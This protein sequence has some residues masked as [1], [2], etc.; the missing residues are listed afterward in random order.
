MSVLSDLTQAGRINGTTMQA[1]QLVE[2]GRFE[3]VEAPLPEPEP[4]Q[5]R[6]RLEGC[7][8]C[9]SNV[10]PFEGRDWFTYPMEPGALGHEGW[11]HIDALGEGVKGLREGDRVAFLGQKSYAQYDVCNSSAV[12]PAPKEL[13]EFPGEPLG[14]CMNIFSRSRIKAGDKVAI[15]GVGFLGALLTQLAAKEGAEVI[16]VA[17][18][19]YALQAAEQFGA[20]HLV[21]MDDHNRIIQEVSDLTGGV[22]CDVVIEATGKPWPLDLAAELTKERGR[23]IVAGFHQDGPRQ[24]NMFLWNWRGLDVINAHERDEVAYIKGMEAAID[25]V[26][27]FRLTPEPL[28]THRFGLNHLTEALTLTKERPDGFMKALISMES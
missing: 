18:K 21:T 3:V 22:F 11:G 24:I 9:A 14:C 17:R 19:P 2:P 12:V 8:V 6:I 16:A 4:G 23:L 27:S 10:P 13:N 15:V 5:V 26:S 7:G 28:Y 20:E 1:A 25:A